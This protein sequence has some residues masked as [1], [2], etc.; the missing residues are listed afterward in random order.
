MITYGIGILPFIKNLKR[1]I[2]D[3]TQPWYADDDGALGALTRL[4]TYFDSLTRHGLRQ[5]YHPEPTKSLLIIRL[6]NLEAGKVFGTCHVFRVCMGARYLGGYIG[7]DEY[8]LN[9]LRE[10]TLM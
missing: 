10:Y 8:K 5:G 6:D 9:W 1:A 3:I 4:E 2:L 7:D